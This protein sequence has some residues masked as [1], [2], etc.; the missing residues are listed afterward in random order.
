MCS[1]SRFSQQYFECLV[2]NFHHIYTLC[3]V[4]DDSIRATIH[5]LPVHAIHLNASSIITDDNNRITVGYNRN[6][7]VPQGIINTS[8]EISFLN[9][10]KITPWV[11]SLIICLSSYRHIQSPL[12]GF[13]RKNII[14]STRR[15]SRPAIYR[16]QTATAIKSFPL[17]GGQ[18]AR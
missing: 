2:I 13:I 12:Q 6:P 17:N 3:E 16:Y 10:P 7:I 4:I 1:N 18:T 8:R 15:S 9:S 5:A 11:N 14:L